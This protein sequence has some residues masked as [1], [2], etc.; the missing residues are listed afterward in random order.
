MKQSTTSTSSADIAVDSEE[1]KA[2]DD[3]TVIEERNVVNDVLAVIEAP[4]EDITL[5]LDSE[6]LHYLCQGT[7]RPTLGVNWDYLGWVYRSSYSYS[8]TLPYFIH[9]KKALPCVRVYIDTVKRQNVFDTARWKYTRHHLLLSTIY[10]LASNYH[11]PI[12][13]QSSMYFSN[14]YYLSS[15]I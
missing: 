14:N 1:S 4:A 6:E 10:R 12:I 5:D 9:R 3:V 8:S 11:L 7:N 13:Y 2:I 15:T